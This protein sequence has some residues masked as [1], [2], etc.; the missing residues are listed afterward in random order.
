MEHVLVTENITVKTVNVMGQNSRETITTLPVKRECCSYFAT[1]AHFRLFHSRTWLSEIRSCVK[2]IVSE[3]E[4]LY[5][6][7]L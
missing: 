3:T 4:K 6:F 1:C 5:I 7:R 2:K